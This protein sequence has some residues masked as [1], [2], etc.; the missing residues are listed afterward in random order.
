MKKSM[1]L[2]CSLRPAV[3][4]EGTVPLCAEC[5]ELVKD[6]RGVK[7]EKKPTPKISSVLA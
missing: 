4:G 2:N 1:C 7:Y 3:K 6:T 5:Q